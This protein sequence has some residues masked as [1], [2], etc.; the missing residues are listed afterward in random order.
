MAQGSNL[1]KIAFSICK[2][3]QSAKNL[4][5]KSAEFVCAV[6]LV[7]SK[8]ILPK[9][10]NNSEHISRLI[11]FSILHRRRQCRQT[12]A[13][14]IGAKK[15]HIGCPKDEPA[16]NKGQNQ[17]PLAIFL[18]ETAHFAQ[19]SPFCCSRGYIY[20]R[21][22]PKFTLLAPSAIICRRNADKDTRQI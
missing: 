7:T 11:T 19:K 20:T 10:S 5:E 8:T 15:T 3:S 14:N 1:I 16:F 9:F 2:C 4:F 18:R 22:V 21:N 6:S 12:R 17:S 13:A